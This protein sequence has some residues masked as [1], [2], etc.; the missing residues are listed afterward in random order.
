MKNKKGFVVLQLSIFLGLLAFLGLIIFEIQIDKQKMINA[1][2]KESTWEHDGEL[3]VSKAT[4]SFKKM[5][6]ASGMTHE[7]LIERY[8]TKA[9]IDFHTSIYFDLEKKLFVAKE[10]SSY[11]NIYIEYYDY[12]VELWLNNDIIKVV[13]FYKV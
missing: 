3:R 5:V 8:S 9:F 4:N 2:I 7:E 11:G 6:E 10:N 12:K 1:N 13:N